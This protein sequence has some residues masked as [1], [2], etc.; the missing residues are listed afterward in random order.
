MSNLNHAAHLNRGTIR[1]SPAVLGRTAV[2]QFSAVR[3]IFA[4]GLTCG[5]LDITAAF[6]NWTLRG[7]GPERLLQ[8][9]ASG[10][11]GPRSFHGGWATAALG[12]AFHFLIAFCAATV[13]YLASRKFEFLTARPILSGIFYGVAVYV[14]MYWIV[15]PLSRIQRLPF[16]VSQ[17]ILAITVH[18]VCV[19]LPI[20]LNIRRFAFRV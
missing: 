20:S 7:V 6:V 10:L 16:S 11:L 3:A 9:I 8:A 13:F 14:F 18:I 4:A 15:I 5:V 17:T 19:G 2:A 12:L 1:V